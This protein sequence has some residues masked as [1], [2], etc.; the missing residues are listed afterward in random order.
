M[1][2]YNPL[3]W[4][5][6]NTNPTLYCASPQCRQPITEGPIAY[7]KGQKV[8]THTP[9][10]QYHLIMH[11]AISSAKPSFTSFD[12]ISMRRAIKL[13]RTG[14]VSPTSLESKLPPKSSE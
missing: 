3:T 9:S 11:R 2:R 8:L 13:A 1:I 6:K 7:E 5:G 12:I 4:F 10:C 14:K